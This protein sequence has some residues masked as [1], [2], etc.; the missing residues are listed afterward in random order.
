MTSEA[1]S[2][3]TSNV[4]LKTEED[5]E[6]AVKFFNVTIQWAAIQDRFKKWRI[7][8][9][10]SKSVHITFTTQRKTCPLVH[11]NNVQS[12]PPKKMMSSISGYTLTGDLPGT[13]TFLQNRNN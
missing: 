6:A 12:P 7:K 9:H 4:S 1:S 13:N 8:A 2:T 5:I 11:I 10:G 3:R